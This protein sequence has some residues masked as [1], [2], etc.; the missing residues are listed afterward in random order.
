MEALLGSAGRRSCR[1]LLSLHYHH[2]N[3]RSISLCQTHRKYQHQFVPST[4]QTHSPGS[5]ATPRRHRRLYTT[6]NSEN[7]TNNNNKTDLD[8][9]VAHVKQR[10]RDSPW[11]REGSQVPPVRRLRSASAMT[12]GLVLSLFSFFLFSN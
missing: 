9:A 11:Q 6:K 1:L 7:N 3:H 12:K 4:A 2:H 8:E 5:I 10:Q